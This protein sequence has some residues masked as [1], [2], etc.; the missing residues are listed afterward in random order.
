MSDPRDDEG[1]EPAPPKRLPYEKPSL[2]WE[3]DLGARPGLVA[4]CNKQAPLVGTC[5]TGSLDS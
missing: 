4:A 2:T 1:L 5:D 3:D